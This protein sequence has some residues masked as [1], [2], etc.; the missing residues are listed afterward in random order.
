VQRLLGRFLA[1]GFVLDDLARA[2]VGQTN[3]AVP[4]VLLLGRLSL[5]GD[6]AARLNDEIV[7]VAARWA[8]PIARKGE[9]KP[10]A[11]DAQ[12]KSWDL[13]LASI[14][15]SSA[16]HVATEVQKNILRS[17]PGDVGELLP[18]LKARCELVASKAVSKLE[19]RGE[20]EAREMVEILEGQK[21]RIERELAKV[22][23][24]QQAF[25]FK[26]FDADEQRQLRD[27]AKFWRGRLDAIPR[28]IALEP[29]R[30]RKGYAVRARRIE[31]VGIAYLWPVTG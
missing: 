19:E 1:Q 17:A 28:E 13:L 15:D 30:I 29:D 31:P 24:P 18:H 4:R 26:D 3:D 2:C 25:E 16:Q 12:E 7:S 11:E 10:Y 20:R 6:R 8:D 5:Y 9:L 27:N 21:K 23:D 14:S 22:E